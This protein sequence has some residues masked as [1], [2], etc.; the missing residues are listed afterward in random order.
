[1]QFPSNPFSK[2]LTHEV[3]AAACPTCCREA[4]DSGWDHE[5]SVI[6]MLMSAGK[7]VIVSGTTLMLTLF[8]MC[9]INVPTLRAVGIC[10]GLSMSA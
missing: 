6:Y 8:A 9:I 3:V 5:E 7:T 1:M 10:S 2:K 4:L